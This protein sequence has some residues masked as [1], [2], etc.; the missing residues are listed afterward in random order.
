MQ[1]ARAHRLRAMVVASLSQV[2]PAEWNRLA[3]DDPFLRYEFL[4]ALEET[5][6]VGNGTGWQPQT[7]LLLENETLVGVMPLYRKTHSFGEYVFDW[8]WADAYR[9]YGLRYYPKLISAIPFTPATGSRLLAETGRR[10]ELLLQAALDLVAAEK[11]SSLHILFPYAGQA[12]ELQ[13]LGFMLRQG[14]QFHWRNRNYE[15]FEQFL[16]QLNHDKRK[17]IR[18]ER[19]RVKHAGITFRH[20]SGRDTKVQDWRFFYR[21]YCST[22]H[23]HGSVPYLNVEFFEKLGQTLPDNILLIVAEKAERPIASALNIYNE[24]TLWGRYWGALEHFPALHYETCYYQAIEFCIERKIETF[25]GGAQGEQKLARG[26]LPVKTRS[27]HCLS[28]PRF[29]AA[30]NRF[31]EDEARVVDH[32]LEELTRR[33]PFKRLF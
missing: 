3:G 32:H 28:D 12:S 20:L 24:R 2:A 14:L 15:S 29:A 10:R 22:Y 18:Q 11:I 9:R 6:C 21:C 1:P 19:R 30:I 31:L 4:S 25:E 5:R 13:T 16:S 26:F 23:E 7:I 33:S 8:A 17:K 27:A